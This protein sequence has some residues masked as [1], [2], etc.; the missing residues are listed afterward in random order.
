[1]FKKE[2]RKSDFFAK[3]MGD[4]MGE[5]DASEQPSCQAQ[6]FL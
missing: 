4:K 1:M 3:M 2:R 6:W 5:T